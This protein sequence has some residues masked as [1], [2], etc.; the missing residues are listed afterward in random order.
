MLSQAQGVLDA[1]TNVHLSPA[2]GFLFAGVAALLYG[3]YLRLLPKP[4]PGIPYNPEATR[5]LFGDAPSMLK[6]T[7]KTGEFMAW[8][9]KQSENMN[10]PLCQIFLRPLSKPTLVLADWREAQDVLM[11]RKDFDRSSFTRDLMAPIAHHHIRMSTGSEWKDARKLTQDLMIPAFLHKVASPAIYSKVLDFL[12][13]WELKENLSEGRPFHA[14][15]DIY[16]TILDSVCAFSFGASFEYAAVRPQ[17]DLLES[18][19]PEQKSA[20]KGDID[21]PIRFPEAAL[22]ENLEVSLTA[23]HVLEKLMN[24]AAPKFT[25]WWE[26]MRP[27]FRKTLAAKDRFVM[28]QIDKSVKKMN[29]NGTADDSWVRSAVDHMILRETVLAE[30]SGREPQFFS[31]SMSDE[32]I[33]NVVGGHETT[34]NTLVWGLKFLTDNPAAQSRLRSALHAAHPA[35]LAEKRLPALD[36]ITHTTIPYLDATMDEML[37]LSAMPITREATCDTELLGHHIPKGSVVLLLSNGPSFLSPS[38]EI[39][40][41]KRSKTSQTTRV[42]QWNEAEDMRAYRPERWLARGEDGEVRFDATAGPQLAFGLGQRGCSG[43]RL[44]YAKMRIVLTLMLWEFELLSVPPSL[45]SYAAKDGLAHTP[46]QCFIRLGKV[47]Y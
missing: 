6:E 39:P 43:R 1:L 5:S 40:E 8:M 23:G 21:D 24:S 22:H 12:H 28:S 27:S 15:T 16:H 11:K 33:F 2:V 13:L 45:S 7:V 30:K 25:L 34:A 29:A 19:T 38:F 14:Q 4:I 46:R 10:A 37:R 31:P 18:L 3:V 17:S 47:K 35:A 26:N 32:I 9:R 42:R 20:L 44:A 36:E 41:S